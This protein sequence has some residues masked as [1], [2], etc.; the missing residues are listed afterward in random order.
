MHR[1]KFYS[2]TDLMCGYQL[3]RAENIMNSY[4]LDKVH[5]NINEIIEFYNI[6]KYIDEEIFL[7]SW[8][9]ED[10]ANF[11][12]IIKKYKSLIG[13]FLSS[14]SDNNFADVFNV[15]DIEYKY[16]YWKL[17]EKYKVYERI[18]SNILYNLLQESKLM[19]Y[20]ILGCKK[21]VDYYGQVIKMHLLF[22]EAA[23][24]LLLEKYEVNRINN[25]DEI[26]LPKEL[27]QEDKEKIILNYIKS[28]NPNLNYLRMIVDIQSTKE[29]SI[30]DRTRLKARKCAEEAE[31]KLFDKDTW[32]CMETIVIFSENQEEAVKQK[33]DGQKLT[34]SYSLRWIKDNKDYNTLMN[35]F[36]YLFNFAD[37][38]A[39]I[40]L[41]NKLQ[42][43]EVLERDMFMHSKNAYSV[44]MVYRRKEALSQLQMVAYYQQ[45]TS[46]GIR[47]EDI[48]EWFFESYVL[49][50]FKIT[51]FR[52]KMPSEHS[53]YI[54]KC[55]AVLPEM[56][57]IL[58]Q[59]SLFVED[60]SIDHELLQMSS[61]HLIYKDI[62]SLLK[63]KYIYGKGDEFNLVSYYLFSDQCMLMYVERIGGKYHNFYDLLINEKV[64]LND[65]PDYNQKK[66]NWLIEHRYIELDSDRFIKFCDTKSVFI[67]RDLNINGVISYWRYPLYLRETIDNMEGQGIV[68]FESMLFSRAEQDYFNYHL[69]KSCFNNALDLRNMYSHGT[70]PNGDKSEDIHKFNYMIFLKLFILII[71]KIN[72][73]FCIKCK[74]NDSRDATKQ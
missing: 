62:P 20:K 51:D 44:G 40:T 4:D 72:D 14:I 10:I 2:T 63:K 41:V 18:S 32:M 56:E 7:K 68:E 70:Q 69:N 35:N 47:L 6:C 33:N 29:F 21:I 38:Q 43:M 13:K 74:P 53:L 15:V 30:T 54:E 39:R 37:V 34:F 50:E 64:S 27:T 71:I 59:F 23:A 61:G 9:A 60:N 25:K 65:Y 31:S 73:E 11:K 52:I 67:L 26:H 49:E 17:I 66:L 28:T 42:E 12:V 46:I 48:I 3:S 36:I 45:L 19:L 24:E 55:R 58:K 1:V 22:D 16:D 57:S 8:L 5:Y